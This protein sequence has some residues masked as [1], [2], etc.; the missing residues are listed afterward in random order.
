M[1]TL[2]NADVKLNIF[3]RNRIS[4][5]Y[6]GKSNTCSNRCKLP[7]KD[8]YFMLLSSYAS[9]RWVWSENNLKTQQNALV[10]IVKRT[11]CTTFKKLEENLP[12]YVLAETGILTSFYC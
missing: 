5:P 10:A 9:K 4:I 2:Y 3:S 11:P 12:V 7:P 6:I 1:C 8:S